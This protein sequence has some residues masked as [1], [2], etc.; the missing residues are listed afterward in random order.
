MAPVVSRQHE[1]EAGVPHERIQERDFEPRTAIATRGER[2]APRAARRD[3]ARG[4][5]VGRGGPEL[6]RARAERAE[7]VVDVDRRAVERDVGGSAY[8]EG[9]DERRT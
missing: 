4:A 8:D 3:H 9:R 1:A 2:L 5:A 7:P 6:R